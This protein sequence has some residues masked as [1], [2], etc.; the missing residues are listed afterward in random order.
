MTYALSVMNVTVTHFLFHC[1]RA[2]KFW[3][4]IETWI[5]NSLG[6]TAPLSAIDVLFGIPFENDR[7]LRVLNYIIIYGKWFIY[8]ANL[9]CE[10]HL[11]FLSF[12][13]GLKSHIDTER[14]IMYISNKC[15]E[16][17][18]KWSLLYNNL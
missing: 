6:I 3:Q 7:A 13:Q 4:Q 18:D 16:F 2:S 10:Q 5:D 17:E 8:R 1:A 12:L 14:H 9:N 15:D 11:F